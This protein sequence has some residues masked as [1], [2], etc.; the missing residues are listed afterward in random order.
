MDLQRSRPPA[1]FDHQPPRPDFTL[2]SD[3]LANGEQIAMAH[4]Y[5]GAGG[6]NVSPQLRWSGF[7]GDTRGFAVTVFDPD[8]PSPSGWWHWLFFGLP[9]ACTELPA[10]AGAGDGAQVLPDGAVMLRN[11]FGDHCYDGPAPPPGDHHHRYFF[12]VHALDTD[13]LG[14]T[15]D[16]PPTVG[17]FQLAVHTLARAHIMVTFAT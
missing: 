10:G 15:G 14:L 6:D 13:E 7:P 4:V 3:D 9:A 5:T 12:T 2:S 16:E 17:G 1:P 8:A 11:D